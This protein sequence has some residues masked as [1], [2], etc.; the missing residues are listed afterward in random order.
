[1]QRLFVNALSNCK[2]CP[3]IADNGRI[4]AVLKVNNQAI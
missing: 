1:M 2:V 4:V 3:K